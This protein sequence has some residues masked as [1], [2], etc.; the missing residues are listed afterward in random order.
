M[1][2]FETSK[3]ERVYH[4]E[5]LRR[6]ESGAISSLQTQPKVRLWMPQT[7]HVDF[8]YFDE[9]LDWWVFDEFKGAQTQRGINIRKAFEDRRVEVPHPNT[10]YRITKESRHIGYHKND[11]Y[12]RGT[13]LLDPSVP[14]WE[15]DHD[16]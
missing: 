11:I 7:H 14:P 1:G 3:A 10:L 4:E 6:E 15:N 5:L 13:G 16:E 2:S 12:P 9:R 8:L